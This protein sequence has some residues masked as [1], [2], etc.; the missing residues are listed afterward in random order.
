MFQ[1]L[2][3]IVTLLREHAEWLFVSEGVTQSLRRDEI[4]VAVVQQRLMLSCWTENG[5]RSWRVLAWH[6]DGSMV[7]FEVS[8][9]MGAEL[10][11]V[12]LIPLT[13][14]NAVVT[15]IR[16]A[17]QTRCAQLAQL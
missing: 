5:T 8:R 9:R 4:D 2:Q 1:D 15:T 7:T 13:S 16:A 17:R 6:W 10:S 11:L 14:A 3:Q 12:E